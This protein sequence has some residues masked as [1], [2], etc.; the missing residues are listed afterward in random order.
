MGRLTISTQPHNN[1]T[2]NVVLFGEPGVGKS[3]VVNLIARKNVVR[4]LSGVHGCTMQSTRYDIPIDNTNFCVFETVGLEE[5]EIR[6]DGYLAALEKA[7]EFVHKLGA[8]GGVHL[9]LFCM[10]A[11]RLTAT[12]QSNYRLFT[13]VVVPTKVPIALVV[14]GLEREVE[15]ED[16]W[17]KNKTPVER[18]GLRSD[19]HVCITTVTDRT[20]HQDRNY[21][22]S[23]KRIRELLK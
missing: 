15:M 12:T 10:R 4:V 14:T 13:E 22:E 5:P 19:G 23:Q 8:A 3:A 17:T 11:T 1:P 9:L 18:Y 20:P 16:W 6:G 21:S 7:Y 2:I